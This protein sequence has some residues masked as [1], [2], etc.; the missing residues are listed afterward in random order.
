METI[1]GTTNMKYLI[2]AI[3]V[4]VILLLSSV[5]IVLY[6]EN[7]ENSEKP[8]LPLRVACVGD[9]ITQ[10]S[11]YPDDLWMLLG[12]SYM[13]E[14]FGS[15][16]STAL[17]NS[18]KPYMN[19]PAFHNAKNYLPK[20]VVIMLGT[21]DAAPVNY[22]NIGGFTGDYEK[23]VGEFQ[24]LTSKPKIWL[25]IPPPILNNGSGPNSANLVDGVIPRIEQVANDLGLPLIDV[26]SA[27]N[28]HPEYYSTD[29]VHP[30][31][32]GAQTIAETVYSAITSASAS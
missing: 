20:V 10:G 25:A 27:M 8:I 7:A 12:D 26:Y 13:V 19:Q 9:S 31:N 24:N 5:L 17:L 18:G 1:K 6:F 2:A 23:M 3:A 30:N 28:N 15:G 22:V 16:G 29:G 14:N 4:I 32:A 11:G 21:N